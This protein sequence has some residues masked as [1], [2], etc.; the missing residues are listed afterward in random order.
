MGAYLWV[1]ASRI[2]GVLAVVGG[3]AWLVK[4]ALI[5]Q[6]HHHSTA[7]S[8]TLVEPRNM[9][10]ATQILPWRAGPKW[11]RSVS[12]RPLQRLGRSGTE[13]VENPRGPPSR[14]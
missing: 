10:L 1:M 9:N 13:R 8:F 2:A 7:G 4:F 3:A 14:R 5:W 12:G 6:N 11:P